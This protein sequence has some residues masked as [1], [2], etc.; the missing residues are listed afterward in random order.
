MWKS[1]NCLLFPMFIARTKIM[2]RKLHFFNAYFGIGN[3]IFSILLKM[4]RLIPHISQ[5]NFVLGF[6][7]R[8]F[9]HS[10]SWTKK[11]PELQL[12]EK[13]EKQFHYWSPPTITY[14]GSGHTE[15]AFFTSI[16][17]HAWIFLHCVW[18][19]FDGV[20]ICVIFRSKCYFV[21]ARRSH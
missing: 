2:L 7:M 4:R 19:W 21:V 3:S 18:D 11:Q 20:Y 14:M 1:I 9:L 12:N 10:P 17:S 13:R 16:P 6:N 5:F 15:I 8:F